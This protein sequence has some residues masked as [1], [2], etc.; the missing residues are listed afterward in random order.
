MVLAAQ[1][2]ERVESRASQGQR[3]GR[4]VLT[5]CKA[6]GGGV[7]QWRGGQ[8]GRAPIVIPLRVTCQRE[9]G[10]VVGRVGGAAG[11]GARGGAGLLNPAGQ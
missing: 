4:I 1:G 7:I 11:G 2:L 9:T 10:G 8:P 5:A 6:G 3:P